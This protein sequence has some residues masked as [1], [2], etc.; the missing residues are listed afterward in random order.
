MPRVMTEEFTPM[1]RVVVEAKIENFTDLA[2]ADQGVMPEEDV[3]SV[4]VSDALIDTGATMVSLPGDMIRKLGLKKVRTR[5]MNTA[6][7]PVEADHYSAIRLTVQERDCVIDVMELPEGVPP[8]IGQVPL[9]LLDFVVNPADRTLI[10]NP[11]HDG[12]WVY[13]AYCATDV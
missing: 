7:G 6:G 8:L 1:G 10:G 3:R 5:R 2:F 13:E 11:R 4:I 12:E 9:E